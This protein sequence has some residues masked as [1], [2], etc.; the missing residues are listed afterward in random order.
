[1]VLR[2]GGGAFLGR[3]L[4]VFHCHGG[5][6]TANTFSDSLAEFRKFLGPEHEQSNPENHEYM[7]GLKKS[8]E[9]FMSLSL[10]QVFV[11]RELGAATG[12]SVRSARSRE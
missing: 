7:H 9:H 10:L 11:D 12:V 4:L 2:F 8:F 6:E 1:L 3:G 5:L